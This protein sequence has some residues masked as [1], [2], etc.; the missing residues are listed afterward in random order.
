MVV[1]DDGE[2]LARRGA[3]R[4]EEARPDACG[5]VDDDVPGH[6]SSV[7]GSAAAAAAAITRPRRRC[8]C[9]AGLAVL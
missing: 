6:E 9:E 5:R 7:S 2:L 1:D 4:E 8:G 3:R